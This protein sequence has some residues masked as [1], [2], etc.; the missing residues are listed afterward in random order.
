M[1]SSPPCPVDPGPLSLFLACSEADDGPRGRELVT[2]SL[3]NLAGPIRAL[4]ETG[5]ASGDLPSPSPI[6]VRREPL[7]GVGSWTNRPT[8]AP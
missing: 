2:C 5:S 7:W 4:I 6:P 3:P 8:D 1:Y